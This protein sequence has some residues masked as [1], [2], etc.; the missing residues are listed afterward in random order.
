MRVFV[1]NLPAHFSSPDGRLDGGGVN[2][3][4]LEASTNAVIDEIGAM[5]LRVVSTSFAPA[6]SEFAY[7]GFVGIFTCEDAR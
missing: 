2:T 5:G 1:R 6:N 7:R 4:L 3:A